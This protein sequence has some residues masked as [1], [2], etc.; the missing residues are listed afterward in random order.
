MAGRVA[1]LPVWVAHRAMRGIRERKRA[2]A[3]ATVVFG[4]LLLFTWSKYTRTVIVLDGDGLAVD[5]KSGMDRYC[6]RNGWKS[7][8]EDDRPLIYSMTAFRNELD[9]LELRLNELDGVVDKHIVME[10]T[11]THSGK[12]KE[13]VFMSHKHEARFAPFL[14]RIVHVVENNTRD[15]HGEA[16][17]DAHERERSQRSALVHGL[18]MAGARAHDLVVFSDLDEIP[19]ADYLE[20]LRSCKGYGFPVTVHTP[21]YLYDLGCRM[22]GESWT[23]IKVVQRRQLKSACGWSMADVCPHDL[24]DDQAFRLGLAQMVPP[25]LVI[26]EGGWHLTWFMGVEEMQKKLAAYSHP[27]RNTERNRDPRMLNCLR[28]R[29]KHVNMVDTGARE[30][31]FTSQR[32]YPRYIEKQRRDG[33]GDW[34]KFFVRPDDVPEPEISC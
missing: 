19:R 31:P 13:L 12:P 6:A 8:P 24:R 27:E 20:L 7:V 29:C 32:V 15:Q 23:R 4:A 26:H 9:M 1:G 2:M 14:D 3:W 18:D 21:E 30:D 11:I 28:K 10:S 5:P 22:H 34:I 16:F 25:P 33:E 17:T